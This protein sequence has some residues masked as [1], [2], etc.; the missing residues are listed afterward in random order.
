LLPKVFCR[1]VE[2]DKRRFG[3]V[4]CNGILTVRR[5]GFWN[6]EQRK[7]KESLAHRVGLIVQLS[8]CD[9]SDAF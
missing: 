9:T 1:Y 3:E 2:R 4:L 6:H 5:Q 8:A 7:L